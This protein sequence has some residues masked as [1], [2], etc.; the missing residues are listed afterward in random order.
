MRKILT[1]LIILTLSGCNSVRHELFLDQT[2]V[3]QQRKMTH[4]TDFRTAT[5]G[6]EM[7]SEGEY[8]RKPALELVTP[9]KASIPGAMGLPFT[10][11]IDRCILVPS[12]K[13]KN[14][15]YYEAPSEKS[16]ATH[17]MLGTVVKGEDKIGVRVHRKN[18]GMEWYFDNSDY[19]KMRAK[20]MIWNR[21]ISRRDN[22]EFKIR[23]DKSMV[24]DSPFT[25]V[26]LISY[27]GYVNGNYQLTYREI[28]QGREYEKDF[29]IPKS[30][31]GFTAVSIKG[32]LIEIVSHTSLGVKFRVLRSFAR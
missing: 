3:E 11:K 26:K 21:R 32:C 22:V 4:S 7:L 8:M 12:W 9:V 5:L 17:A 24:M 1:I 20:S 31:S 2:A 6:D 28:N 13:S 30:K 23:E 14:Y 29:Q 25:S 19:N 18:N 10:F 16:T 27:A 15:T